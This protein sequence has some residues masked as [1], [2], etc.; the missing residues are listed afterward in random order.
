MSD[1]ENQAAGAPVKEIEAPALPVTVHAQYIKDLSFENPNAPQIFR[2]GQK[3][4]QLDMSINLD[5]RTIQDKEVKNLH[6]VSIKINVT[7]RNE[8]QAAFIVEIVY[9]ALLSVQEGTPPERLRPLLFID[10]PQV[11]FPFAR[12]VIADLTGNAGFPPLLLN[13]VDFRQLYMSHYAD[14]KH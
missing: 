10:I 4:P 12:Q 6:E 3:A 2:R 8:D 14:T 1:T 9:A 7:A 5:A 11:I 13:P